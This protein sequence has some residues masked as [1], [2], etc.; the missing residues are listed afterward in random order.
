MLKKFFG[1]VT[2]AMTYGMAL[3]AVFTTAQKAEQSRLNPQKVDSSQVDSPKTNPPTNDQPI[4]QNIPY[5]FH[6]ESDRTDIFDIPVQNDEYDMDME[7]QDMG[8]QNMDMQDMEMQDSGMHNMESEQ[9]NPMP[10][11]T[12]PKTYDPP[13]NSK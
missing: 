3:Q 6:V 13:I 10:G 12:G 9:I 11:Y 7:M 4:D 5:N 8:M 2:I 1:I